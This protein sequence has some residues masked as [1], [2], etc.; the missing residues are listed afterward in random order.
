M[1]HFQVKIGCYTE[2][3]HQV[4]HIEDIE[5]KSVRGVKAKAHKIFDN[6]V[7]SDQISKTK[8]MNARWTDIYGRCIKK[9]ENKL[10]LAIGLTSER[11][12]GGNSR[13]NEA[14]YYLQKALKELEGET[15]YEPAKEEVKELKDDINSLVHA[16]LRINGV[17]KETF[18]N[19]DK[20][21]TSDDFTRG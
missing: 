3:G 13:I 19:L 1:T 21:C 17:Y 9:F 14:R 12:R 2:D 5:A 18:G 10:Y 11:Y 16:S 15:N 8:K 6:H 20:G 7:I 4:V